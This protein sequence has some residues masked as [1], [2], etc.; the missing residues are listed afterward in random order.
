M[1]G[2]SGGNEAC[3]FALTTGRRASSFSVA[4]SSRQADAV[5]VPSET[6]VGVISNQSLAPSPPPPFSLPI[7]KPTGTT[8]IHILP[9]HSP[10]ALTPLPLGCIGEICVL[11]PQVTRG[12]VRRELN[13]GVFV[14]LKGDEGIGKKGERLYR[15][16]DLG[17]WVVAEWEG[18]GEQEGWIECLG[19]KDGQVKVNGLRC[20]PTVRLIRSISLTMSCDSIEVGEIEE[21]LSSKADPAIIRGIVD[22]V[23]APDVGTALVAFLELSPAFVSDGTASPST[24]REQHHSHSAGSVSVLPLSTSPRF[25]ALCESLKARLGEKLPTYMVPRYWLAVSRIPTQGMGK[26]DRKTLRGL[27]EEWDWHGAARSRRANGANG[28]AQGDEEVG[29]RRYT[30]S[31]HFDAARRAWAKVLR[32]KDD[33]KGD[34]IADEDA[35]VKLGG[36]S[37]RFMK[38]VTAIRSEGYPGVAFRDLV[39]AAT[40]ADCA[41]V[42]ERKGADGSKSNGHV[43]KKVYRPFSL[44]PKDEEEALYAELES[45][46]LPRSRISDIYPTAP[47]QDA[48]LAPSFDS[49]CGHYYAQAVYTVGTSEAELP[50]E[51]L[52]H[53]VNEL[54]RRHDVL[55]GVFFVSD[56]LGRTV[57]VLLKPEDEEVQQRCRIEKIEVG[58]SEQLD[59]VISVRWSLPLYRVLC[60]SIRLSCRAGCDKTAKPTRSL[61]ADFRSRS[62]SSACPTGRASSPGVCIMR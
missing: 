34:S 31:A 37:I 16:G 60:L 54:V 25:S 12:Y 14:E 57:S 6:T 41:A 22:K 19:R 29:E 56:S 17:R 62:L 35:F 48:L 49:P 46:S 18:Q 20:V 21:N 58:D 7:G 36:D 11:G 55:R 44:I 53:G 32:L 59:A 9:S 1:C 50:F 23:D 5:S 13:E 10:D 42:L 27:A 38:L 15:T 52:Q 40:L 33:P 30:R 28:T 2:R 39:E 61:G 51:R 8:R 26:A 4:R 24:R 47:A 3:G 45:A 43:V